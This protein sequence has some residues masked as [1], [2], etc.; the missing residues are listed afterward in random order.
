MGGAPGRRSPLHLSANEIAQGSGAGRH[1]GPGGT[2]RVGGRPR[3]P[4]A[5]GRLPDGNAHVPPAAEPGHGS[6]VPGCP[7]CPGD[8]PR[9]RA[10]DRPPERGRAGRRHGVRARWRGRLV[11][12]AGWDSTGWCGGRG[13]SGGRRGG[14]RSRGTAGQWIAMRGGPIGPPRSLMRGAI[15]RS[16]RASITVFAR[17][18]GPGPRSR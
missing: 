9:R 11:G 15:L 17:A 5:V 16:V 6:A 1:G 7:G 13:P 12:G 3:S 2:E 8:G 14:V 10:E 18:G 4:T